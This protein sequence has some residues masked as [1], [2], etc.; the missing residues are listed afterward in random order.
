MNSN[1]DNHFMKISTLILLIILIF[2]LISNDVEVKRIEQKWNIDGED[3]LK[4]Y[5]DKSTNS[6]LPILDSLQPIAQ[7]FSI[8]PKLENIVRSKAGIEFKIPANSIQLPLKF[9]KTEEVEIEIIE[10]VNDL[11]YITMNL[12]MTYFDRKGIP[13]LFE[14]GGMFKIVAKYNEKI[15]S[16]KKGTAIQVKIPNFYNTKLA[17]KM[18]KL[19]SRNNWEEKSDLEEGT[20]LVPS[21]ESNVPAFIFKN[22]ND[23]TWYNS[24]YANPDTVCLKGKI[25]STEKDTQFSATMVGIDYKSASTRNADSNSIF[26]VNAIQSKKIKIIALDKEGNMGLSEIITATGKKSY[27][28]NSKE[29]EVCTDIGIIKLTKTPKDIIRN[30]QKF[31]DYIG[32]KDI[33]P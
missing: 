22:L 7:N 14:S 6:I 18:Y 3:N 31:I 1:D 28:K 17:M 4:I 11:D 10:I 20:V 19:N 25:E 15:L 9:P 24:D 29:E 8:D 16:L 13:Y 21:S 26:T 2:P 5:T 23:F 33:V 27:S 30:R 32:I 12:P